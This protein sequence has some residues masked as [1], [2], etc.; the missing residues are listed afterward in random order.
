MD[1]TIRTQRRS[2][3]GIAQIMPKTSTP[4]SEIRWPR[5]RLTGGVLLPGAP[6]GSGLPPLYAPDYE[7]IWSVCEELGLPLNHHSGSAAPDYGPYPE[8]NV[9][10]LLE[11]T[12]WAHRT[13]WH[14]IFAGVMER[15]PG[16]L[17]LHRPARPAP[18]HS[19]LDTTRPDIAP[20]LAGTEW[21]RTSSP[22]SR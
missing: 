14:L 12:W 16:C 17:A 15:H 11:V 2:A 1:G 19:T 13:L 3:R 10:F 8:A 4:L 5:R 6:P 21:A 7:P 20:P 18:E 9:M 22:A